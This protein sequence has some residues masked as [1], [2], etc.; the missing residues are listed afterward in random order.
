MDIF[1]FIINKKQESQF[2]TGIISDLSPLSVKIYPLDDAILCKATTNLIGLQ[3]GSNV[4]LLKIGN[5]FI[6]TN[7]IGDYY[8]LYDKV[9]LKESNETRVNSSVLY[10][11]NT[12]NVTL[13]ANKT[14]EIT[15]CLKVGGV[16]SADFKCVWVKGAGVTAYDRMCSGPASNVADITT[17]SATFMAR[18]YND[19]AGYGTED[20]YFSSITETFIVTTGASANTLKLQWAQVSA[21]ANSTTVYAG[22][23]MEITEVTAWA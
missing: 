18:A 5:Q 13:E 8:K 7:V 10:D 14:Y 20:T 9:L 21:V 19:S 12:F 23:Y 2:F 22:S 6:I 3:L 16:T 1:D 11:D 17:T 4:I 15:L